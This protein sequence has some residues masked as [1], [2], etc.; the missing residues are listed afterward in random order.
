MATVSR[1]AALPY[2]HVPFARKM[3]NSKLMQVNAVSSQARK[4]QAI[5]TVQNPEAIWGHVSCTLAQ[6]AEQ[7]QSQRLYSTVL[8]YEHNSKQCT[9]CTCGL[10]CL[11][12]ARH[13]RTAAAA[14]AMSNPVLRSE[15]L[16]CLTATTMRLMFFQSNAVKHQASARAERSYVRSGVHL[17]VITLKVGAHTYSALDPGPA[18]NFA[19]ELDDCLCR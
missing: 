16:S 12:I 11:Y 13:A 19:V 8:S 1:C 4:I 14:A 17:Y 18:N 10:V 15:S 9:P 2:E 3:R 5:P 7:L 6:L